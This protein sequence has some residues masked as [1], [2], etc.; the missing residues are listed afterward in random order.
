MFSPLLAAEVQLD[1]GARADLPLDPGFEHGLVLLT[2]RARADGQDLHLDYLLYMEPGHSSLA[3]DA[4]EP[5]RLLLL[6]GTP[7][8]E[9][10]LMWWNFVARTAD[11]IESARSD[12]QAG[13]R[14]GEVRRY[15]GARL[16]A[17][18]LLGRPAPPNPMS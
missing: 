9:P 15:S 16:E 14:F 3:V 1:A 7:F 11:E 4:T 12:W 6:G 13:R 18:P 5:A 10:I 17:P 2:G 8:A